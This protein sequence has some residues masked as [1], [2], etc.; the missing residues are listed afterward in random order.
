MCAHAPWQIGHRW[1][2]LRPWDESLLAAEPAHKTAELW[3]RAMRQLRRQP[4]G[5]W[6]ARRIEA[7][8]EKQLLFEE[9]MPEH[10]ADGGCTEDGKI[11][12]APRRPL[13]DVSWQSPPWRSVDFL[14][15]SSARGRSVY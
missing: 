7:E 4:R 12:G 2:Q 13:P 5:D 10:W 15:E 6:A 1:E 11:L 9:R 8:L 3:H 14:A